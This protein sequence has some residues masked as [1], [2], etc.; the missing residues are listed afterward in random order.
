[1]SL[2]QCQ[3]SPPTQGHQDPRTQTAAELVTGVGTVWVA[4]TAPRVWNTDIVQHAPQ[5]ALPTGRVAAVEVLVRASRAS[6]DVVTGA[7]MGGLR[8][9]LPVLSTWLNP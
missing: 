9:A 7:R 8:L 5:L 3:P 4:I 1:M 6:A 2:R